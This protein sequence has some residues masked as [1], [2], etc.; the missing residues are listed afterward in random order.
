[1]HAKRYQQ[2]M[3]FHNIHRLVTLYWAC[4]IALSCYYSN[5]RGQTRDVSHPKFSAPLFFPGVRTFFLLFWLRH[6][7][8]RPSA[9]AHELRQDF[10]GY[11]AYEMKQESGA[12]L[13][14]VFRSSQDY[15]GI[16]SPNLITCE[17]RAKS[18]CQIIKTSLSFAN[19]QQFGVNVK[20]CLMVFCFTFMCQL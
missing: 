10:A 15:R 9:S 7:S 17:A 14:Q 2:R 5:T 8:L 3:C 16:N 18:C 20:I 13:R 12:A 1:M 4:V 11:G 6:A 19:S